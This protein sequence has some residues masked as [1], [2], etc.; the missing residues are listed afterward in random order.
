MRKKQLLSDALWQ[1]ME[2]WIP[3]RK[4]THPRGG[5]KKPID[6]RVIMNAILFV[7]HTGCQW[8][9]LNET[10]LC[11]SST[12]HDRFQLWVAQG[13]FQRL[14]EE[15]LLEYDETKGIDWSWLSMD[16]AMTKAPL[17]GEKKRSESDRPRQEGCQAEPRDG[18]ERHSPWAG[19]LRRQPP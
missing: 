13:V 15:G 17:G 11:A 5:G 12:A 10:G 14:W 7:L 1:K 16:G 19:R 4:S 6:N 8:N 9:A 2:P 18:R 3:P